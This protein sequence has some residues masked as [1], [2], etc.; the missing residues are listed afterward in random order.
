M[1]L[2]QG[3]SAQ[4]HVQPNHHQLH[5]E[6]E[7]ERR[8]GASAAKIER[9]KERKE[10]IDKLK[11]TVFDAVLASRETEAFGT[12]VA[13]LVEKSDMLNIVDKPDFDIARLQSFMEDVKSEWF[14]RKFAM[15]FPWRQLPELQ[16]K[17]IVWKVVLQKSTTELS[18]LAK[19]LRVEDFKAP[20][21]QEALTSAMSS[22]EHFKCPICMDPLL[23]LSPR[24]YLSTSNMWF[25]PL[26]KN[27]HW[28]N[29]PCG[30]AC[31]RECMRMWA[32]TAIN[33]QKASVRC[34]APECSYKLF[35]RDLQ[36]LVSPEA[37]QRHQEHQNAD[38][39]KHLKTAL[40]SDPC[41]KNW[42][43][44]HARPCPDC[45]VIV[46]RSEGCDQMQCICGTNFCYACGFKSCKCGNAKRRDIWKPKANH[47]IK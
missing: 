24:G 2:I 33:D 20:V 6:Q 18:D 21:W 43:K 15:L 7:A 12:A 44:G 46:S 29:E 5:R 16:K 42:L 25:A 35:D 38:Y 11:G 4:L 45:H 1:D 9:E 39:L 40:K 3:M 10:R 27:E 41:L 17:D 30:H 8:A 34:P 13:A 32:E 28:S 23:S 26:H 19:T 31:C 22:S 47:S 36:T 14:Y 37:F